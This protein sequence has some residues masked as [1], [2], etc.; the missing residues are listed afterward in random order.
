[1]VKGIRYSRFVEDGITNGDKYDIMVTDL[2]NN[3]LSNNA[4]SLSDSNFVSQVLG[5]LSR[6]DRISFVNNYE[7]RL[8]A[9]LDSRF[10]YSPVCISELIS[11]SNKGEFDCWDD[12]NNMPY[13]S[14][15]M[16]YGFMELYTPKDIDSNGN[17][18][19]DNKIYA[20]IRN[21]YD[22]RFTKKYA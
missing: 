11:L 12:I 14:A 20:N 15:V 5:L 2:V 7:D 4:Y 13:C 22:M 1:M 18:V 3:R 6:E 16:Y 10:K 9:D 21:I 8:G 19:N 17:I